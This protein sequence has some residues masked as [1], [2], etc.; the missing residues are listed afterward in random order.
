ML[1]VLKVTVY[2]VFCGIFGF[3][4]GYFV[5]GPVCSKA[6]DLICREKEN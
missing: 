2:Y 1:K 3:A 4:L 5:T 6:Y